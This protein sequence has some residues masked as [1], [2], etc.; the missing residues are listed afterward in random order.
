M[1]GRGADQF[2]QIVPVSDRLNNVISVFQFI[3]NETIFYFS[4]DERSEK[5][6]ESAS[7]ITFFL[8]MTIHQ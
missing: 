8:I 4:L 2:L 5:N 7:M 6:V 1:E 3:S